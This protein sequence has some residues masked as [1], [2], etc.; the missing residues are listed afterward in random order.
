M[1]PKKKNEVE[2]MK[3]KQNGDRSNENNIDKYYRLCS[4]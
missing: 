1:K 3:G 4:S 2:E